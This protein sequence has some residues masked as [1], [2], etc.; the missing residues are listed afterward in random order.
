M[1][2]H[3]CIEE[4]LLISPFIN[5]PR[6]VARARGASYALDTASSRGA[7][8]HKEQHTYPS[9][10]PAACRNPTMSAS[11]LARFFGARLVASELHEQAH[12]LTARLLGYAPS[13]RALGDRC[14]VVPG[15]SSCARAQLLVCHAGWIASVVLLVVVIALDGS[16][17]A[18]G[19]THLLHHPQTTHPL[20]C[21]TSR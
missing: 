8:R 19:I 14:T 7:A 9:N 20:H 12:D 6:S 13:K 15:I 3:G 16:Q 10:L 1:V 11:S 4:N 17:G 2:V 21:N 18:L 5:E